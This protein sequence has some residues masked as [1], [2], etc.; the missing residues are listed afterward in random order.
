M[1]EPELYFKP[2]VVTGGRE[3]ELMQEL[4]E[5]F[6]Y[7]QLR[8]QGLSSMAPREVGAPMPFHLTSK[9]G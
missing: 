5:Y 4:K 8:R 6:Y 2:C 7:A 9:K 3:G 1:D